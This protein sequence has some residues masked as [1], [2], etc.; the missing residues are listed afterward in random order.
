MAGTLAAG[1]YGRTGGQ[2]RRITRAARSATSS[3][4]RT[5]LGIVDAEERLRIALAQKLWRDLHTTGYADIFDDAIAELGRELNVPEHLLEHVTRQLTNEGL[6][7]EKSHG[8]FDGVELSRLYG[9]QVAREEWRAGNAVRWKI[10]RAAIAGYEDPSRWSGLDFTPE[11]CKP[12][13]DEPFEALAAATRIL[14]SLGYL[15]LEQASGR[16]HYVALTQ[17]GYDLARDEE[18]LR[19]AFPRNASEDEHAHTAVVPD[20]VSELVTSVEQA[21]R[22]R[23]WTSALDEL[24][25]G[26]T[27]YREGKWADAVGEYYSAVESGLRYRIDEAGA[28]VA[29]GAALKVLAKRAGELDLIPT[30]YQALFG[31]IGSIRSPRRHGR[32]PRPVEVPV[33][34]AEALLMSNH[35]RAL[36]V[37]LA[38][39]PPSS[40][41]ASSSAA[42]T[43]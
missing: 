21:L 13:I 34:P 30:N 35:A 22:A 8:Y 1:A 20:V 9:E 11:K 27:R 12:P 25:R 38:H 14:E 18:A 17:A 36:L 39:R 24:A 4:G 23:A 41:T 26:D 2:T 19:Q 16:A 10:L 37:Y 40:A 28:S 43:A 6:L 31:F 42:S 33:G 32:G 29:E 3:R 7:Y 15:Q 5:T